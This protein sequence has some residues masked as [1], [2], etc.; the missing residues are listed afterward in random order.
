MKITK[1]YIK[2]FKK[3]KDQTIIFNSE[4]YNT[5][6]QELYKKMN[7]TLLSGENGSGKSTIL[8]FI[9]I[10]FRY[11]QRYRERI[12]CDFILSYEINHNNTII[13]IELSK[14]GNLFYI[15][16][17]GKTS[18]I[19]KYD[20]KSRGYVS[21][22]DSYLDCIIPFRDLELNQVTYD[23][24]QSYLP[25][26]IVV[27]GIDIDYKNLS[28]QGNYIGQRLMEYRDIAY[29]YTKSGIGSDFSFGILYVLNKSYTDKQLSSVL[30][31]MGISF[32]P[33]VDIFLN[34]SENEFYSFNEN[35][36]IAQKHF[37]ELFWK[38][39]VI[40][41]DDMNYKFDLKKF[42]QS[43]SNYEVIS[44]F[45]QHRLIYINE[46]YIIKENNSIALSGMS[47]GE[48]IFLCHLFFVSSKI[49]DNIILIWEEPETH[50]NR[51]WAKQ[52][53]PLFTILFNNYD[54][55]I[56]LSSHDTNL[57]NSLFPNQILLLKNNHVTNPNFNTFLANDTE[58]TNNLFNIEMK[59]NPFEKYILSQI[60]DTNPEE[61]KYLLSLLGE[62]FFKFLIYKKLDK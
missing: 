20:L 17:H 57:I 47:T 32:S 37:S 10:I 28:Y 55:H 48:K 26:K 19:Q 38:E 35:K 9:A 44:F 5:I 14:T 60:N 52:L 11:L 1:L 40:S 59:L 6:Q 58:I 49:Q 4:D 2:D 7:L 54:S 23:E 24:I 21:Y 45:V 27:L 15:K 12:P 22:T 39:Y 41:E 53:I 50:L 18:I 30:E 29:A 31:T 13:H 25:S 8:S 51:M 42:L 43:E 62:S 16:K 3:Y 34:F 61:L 33:Y 36:K 56:L 46:F